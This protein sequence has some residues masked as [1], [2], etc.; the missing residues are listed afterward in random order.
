MGQATARNSASYTF[1]PSRMASGSATLSGDLWDPRA[2]L[3]INPDQSSQCSGTNKRGYQCGNTMISR[4]DLS[5]ASDI[6]DDMAQMHPR[7]GIP[8]EM[9][10]RLAQLTLCPRWHRKPGYSQVHVVASKWKRMI[11]LYS[12]TSVHATRP[13]RGVYHSENRSTVSPSALLSPAQSRAVTVRQDTSVSHSR[14]GYSSQAPRPSVRSIQIPNGRRITQAADSEGSALPSPPP[15]PVQDQNWSS[16]STRR[17]SRSTRTSTLNSSGSSDSNSSAASAQTSATST[18]STSLPRTR[19][20]LG[21][22]PSQN[23]STSTSSVPLPATFPDSLSSDSNPAPTVPS[24]TPSSTLIAAT[25][26]PAHAPTAEQLQT[27]PPSRASSPHPP[28][29]PT[30]TPSTQHVA[31]QRKPIIEDCPICQDTITSPDSAVWCR[32][33]CGINVHRDCFAEWEAQCF[34]NFYTRYDIPR[35]TLLSLEQRERRRECVT[36]VYCRSVWQW[37]SREWVSAIE[38]LNRRQSVP[39]SFPD[40][41]FDTDSNSDSNSD[42]Q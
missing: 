21:P 15:S 25:T 10:I 13:R 36:C 30:S 34:T 1:N 33:E 19:L 42:R 31:G 7:Q 16:T 8:F 3:G 40:S 6:L 37:T 39:G 20:L 28:T 27:P 35:G 22:P 17:V 18:S 14:S 2:V 9:L 4:A 23:V 38:Q 26:S 11:G 29:T 24:S 32:A 41:D 5:E 12:S